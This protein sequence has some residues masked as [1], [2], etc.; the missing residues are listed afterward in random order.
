[1]DFVTYKFFPTT[2]NGTL[3]PGSVPTPQSIISFPAILPGDDMTVLLLA[4]YLDHFAP[5]LAYHVLDEPTHS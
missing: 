2:T 5:T 3:Q 1:M 4:C